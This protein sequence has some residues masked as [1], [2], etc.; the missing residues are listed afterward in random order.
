MQQPM[1]AA[2]TV[3]KNEDIPIGTAA[4]IF[5]QTLGG[6]LFVS[7]GLNVFTNKFSEGLAKLPGVNV[8]MVLATGATALKKS[9][10]FA[11]ELLPQVLV[12][13]NDAITESFYASVAMAC[14]G[15]IGS[16]GMEWKSVKGKKLELAAV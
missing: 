1:I 12:A 3:L 11:P 13:Y 14:V 15:F 9:P 16:L 8:P 5:F 7:V 4:V 10:A 6:A 2:Q